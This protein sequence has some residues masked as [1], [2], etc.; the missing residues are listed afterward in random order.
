[1]EGTRT[2]TNLYYVWNISYRNIANTV[3]VYRW[4][5]WNQP[6]FTDSFSSDEELTLTRTTRI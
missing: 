3:Q 4:A 1:L 6:S 5:I 2:I